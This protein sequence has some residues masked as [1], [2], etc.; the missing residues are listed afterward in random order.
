MQKLNDL[1][2]QNNAGIAEFFLMN[3]CFT[4]IYTLSLL[5]SFGFKD[6]NELKITDKVILK[7][8]FCIFK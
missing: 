4:N 3:Q 8:F 5:E 7:Y 6:F 2:K 1:N